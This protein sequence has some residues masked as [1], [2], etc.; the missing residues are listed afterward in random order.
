MTLLPDNED[1]YSTWRVLVL[2][3]DVRGVQVHDTR[4]A[5]LMQV[6]NVPYLLTFNRTDFSRYRGVRTVHPNEV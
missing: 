2:D 6:H 3:H 5:A 1:V 4:L